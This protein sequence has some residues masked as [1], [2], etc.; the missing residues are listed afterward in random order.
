MMYAERIVKEEQ[1]Q[2]RILRLEFGYRRVRLPKRKEPLF[3][4]VVR[5][6]GEEPMMLFTNLEIRRSRSSLWQVIESYLTRWRVEE[7]IRFL[8]QSYRI[9]DIRVLTYTRLQNMIVLVTAVAYFATVYLGLKTK[10]RVLA[11]HVLRAARRLFGIP[12]FRFYALADGI[13]EFLFSLRSG[14]QSP[15]PL[16]KLD[17]EQK[18]LFDP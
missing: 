8:K 2:E 6:L 14:P 11:R 17:F 15:A 1:G 7:T 12:D 9:E 5:G 4:V 10:L 16:L 13:R 3:L 18:S